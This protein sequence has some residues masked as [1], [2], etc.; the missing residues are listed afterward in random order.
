VIIATLVLLLAA[1][2][3]Q[4]VELPTDRWDVVVI[5]DSSLWEL[6]NALAV[7]IEQDVGVQVNLESFSI[8]G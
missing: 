8:G 6:G 7:Q 4:N 3:T 1:C 2:S 5:S